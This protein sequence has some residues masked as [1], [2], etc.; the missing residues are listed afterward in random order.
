MPAE[1]H[2]DRAAVVEVW[3][4]PEEVPPA[5]VFTESTL[6]GALQRPEVRVAAWRAHTAWR[7]WQDAVIEW[8]TGRGLTRAD[9]MRLRVLPQ[10]R[11]LPH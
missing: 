1:L 3:V 2:R 10:R 11:W 6:N 8:G 7:R 9:L 4:A 5:H